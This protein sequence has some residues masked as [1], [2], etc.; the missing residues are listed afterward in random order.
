[1]GRSITCTYH[2]EVLLSNTSSNP[3]GGAMSL[4]EAYNFG[5]SCAEAWKGDLVK[6]VVFPQTARGRN[7]MK[8]DFIIIDTWG[9][10]DHYY[11]TDPIPLYTF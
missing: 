4:K 1:M 6:V 2:C 7:A 10:K 3:I 11:I 9:K 8:K 5:K